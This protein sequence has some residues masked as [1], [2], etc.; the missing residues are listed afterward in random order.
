[1][2]VYDLPAMRCQHFP[3]APGDLIQWSLKCF[4]SLAIY[5][6]GTFNEAWRIPSKTGVLVPMDMEQ[7]DAQSELQAIR[8]F[9]M[10]AAGHPVLYMNTPLTHDIIAN[11]GHPYTAHVKVQG[12]E[13]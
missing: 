13:Y 5:L 6:S 1:M 12:F 4:N 2:V 11:K 10:R 7:T 8:N 9:E 3:C